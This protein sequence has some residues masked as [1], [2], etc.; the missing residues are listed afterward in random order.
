M[1][2]MSYENQLAMNDAQIRMNVLA[3]NLQNTTSTR[4]DDIYHPRTDKRVITGNQYTYQGNEANK[5]LKQGNAVEENLKKIIKNQEEQRAPIE[6]QGILSR[7]KVVEMK[8]IKPNPKCRSFTG[9]YMD[10]QCLSSHHE[11]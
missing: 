8:E 5:E 10:S 6:F 7:A 11:R 3:E 9:L 2:Q 4:Y 1:Q